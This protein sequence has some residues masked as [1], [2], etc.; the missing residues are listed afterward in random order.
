MRARL[1]MVL[2]VAAALGAAPAAQAHWRHHVGFSLWWG[3]GWW[4]DP[5]WRVES[6]PNGPPPD[7]AVVDTDVSP[8]SARVYLEGQLIGTA[9]DFDG[10]PDYLYLKPGHYTIEFRLPG[11]ASQTVAVDAVSGRYYPLD[12]K[13]VRVPGEAS[14][15]WYDRPSG[16]P[17]GRVFGPRESSPSGAGDQ[18]RQRP[19][20]PDTSL[21]PELARPGA[22]AAARGAALD[23]KVTPARASVYL[24]GEFVGTGAELADLERG[25][26]V[27]PGQHR[28]EVVA[29]GFQPRTLTVTV[30]DGAL[31]QVIVELEAEGG[32][33]G[34][35]DLQ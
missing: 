4:W 18:G 31:Q 6:V 3:P 28:L 30:D 14:P 9:D 17:V 22:P 33:K 35:E 27:T 8:E 24:D 7:L 11:Y 13:L 1:V 2:A 5:W 34:Q 32:Q 21:R 12:N 20:H 10:Y 15:P 19:A 23:L 26:A 29:P 25:L 16:L